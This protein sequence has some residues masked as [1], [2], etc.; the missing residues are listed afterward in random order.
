MEHTATRGEQT[1][2]PAR[3][4]LERFVSE[5]PHPLGLVSE[6]AQW[7]FM[8]PVTRRYYCDVEGCGKECSGGTML[9]CTR[10]C[11]WG[12]CGACQ[13]VWRSVEA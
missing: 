11:D 3:P 9:L 8:R 6:R 4:T 2:G 13:Q 5:H 12:V 7:E 1:E 10:G